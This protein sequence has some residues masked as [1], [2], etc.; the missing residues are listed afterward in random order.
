MWDLRADD[1]DSYVPLLAISGRLGVVNT[2]AANVDATFQLLLWLSG[3][4]MSTQVSAASPD[5]TLF[6]QSHLRSPGRWVEKAVPAPAAA[7]YG[8]VTEAAFRHEQWLAALRLP[9]RAEYLAA[10]D[11]A[12]AAAVR[13]DKT[14]LDA[15]LE[16]DAKWRKITERLGV[17]KQKAAYRH[18]LGLE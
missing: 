3:D 16:A 13:G 8:D 14:V 4:A 7:Q 18:S 11:E 6:R 15:L 2:K 9:G 12:V 1:E 17:E 5:T 10:L